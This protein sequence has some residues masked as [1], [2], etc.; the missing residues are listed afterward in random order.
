MPI[1]GVF[2]HNRGIG[3]DE[4]ALFGFA[5]ALLSFVSRSAF[6]ILADRIGFHRLVHKAARPSRHYS[7]VAARL[8]YHLLSNVLGYTVYCM[9]ITSG[10]LLMSGLSFTL[11]LLVP[12]R[13]S[14]S[15]QSRTMSTQ[16]TQS[17]QNASNLTTEAAVPR[18]PFAWRSLDIRL[19]ASFWIAFVTRTLGIALFNPAINLS[20]SLTFAVIARVL[21]SQSKK[22]SLTPSSIEEEL[23][24]RDGDSPLPLDVKDGDGAGGDT[25]EENGKYVCSISASS[26][27]GSSDQDSP[28]HELDTVES[29][30]RPSENGKSVVL[31][32]ID[33]KPSS[34]AI[35]NAKQAEALG[36]E[37]P[38]ISVPA[39]ASDGD[40][41][42]SQTNNTKE[43][44]LDQQR[45]RAYGMFRAF[46][47]LGF[48]LTSCTAVIIFLFVVHVD[49][50]Q[51]YF[52]SVLVA[53]VFWLVAAASYFFFRPGR[54]HSDPNLFKSIT[55]FIG[56]GPILRFFA[57]IFLQGILYGIL[58]TNLYLYASAAVRYTEQ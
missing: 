29:A 48:L 21:R 27:G 14:R 7:L 42:Q 30:E 51:T 10:V 40:C 16:S 34:S 52:A 32:V 9:Q 45:V 18:A 35:Q 47:S 39:A 25:T 37:L 43:E 50:S 20:D 26:S 13:E 2:L 33:E 28:R 1:V 17:M 4:I 44:A 55:K 38:L 31:N 5:A 19:D 24:E 54:I 23:Q 57:L 46:G 11:M 22:S 12:V 3:A 53:D 8:E 36:S 15:D 41:K 56:S 6:A 58:E 49:P